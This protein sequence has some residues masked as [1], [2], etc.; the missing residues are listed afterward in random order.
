ML[1]SQ[2]T[3]IIG[4]GAGIGLAVL[5]LCMLCCCYRF[6]KKRKRATP[7]KSPGIPRITPDPPS[8][9]VRLMSASSTPEP[10]SPHTPS[11][12]RHRFSSSPEVTNVYSQK[13]GHHSLPQVRPGGSHLAAY[14]EL[15]RQS[16]P[17][18]NELHASSTDGSQSLLGLTPSRGRSPIPKAVKERIKDSSASRSLERNRD[19]AHLRQYDPLDQ[20][21]TLAS[22]RNTPVDVEG[23]VRSYMQAAEIESAQKLE[24]ATCGQI[25]FQ[26]EYI[27]RTESIR[28]RLLRA[29]NLP[30]MDIGGTSDPYVEVRM[31]DVTERGDSSLPRRLAQWRTSHQ[32]KTLDPVFNEFYDFSYPVSR[33]LA[34]VAFLLHVYDHDRLSRDDVIGHVWVRLKGLDLTSCPRM[35]QNIVPGK[36]SG[37]VSTCP[38]Y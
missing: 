5:L 30:A 25:E 28:L 11:Q 22:A 26:L 1:F 18:T 13:K 19:L 38:L 37:S 7:P 12:Q 35:W 15:R 34:S 31:I 17:S 9:P 29:R 10:Q 3:V 8:Y 36:A 21:D 24:S 14:Q 27:Y 20:S 23:T 2:C 4:A 33:S 32:S 16:L 6:F